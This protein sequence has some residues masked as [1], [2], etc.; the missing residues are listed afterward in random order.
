MLVSAALKQRKPGNQ[1]VQSGSPSR[2]LATVPLLSHISGGFNLAPRVEQ[3]FYSITNNTSFLSKGCFTKDGLGFGGGGG[4]GE[5][6]KNPTK[7][8]HLQACWS[9]PEMSCSSPSKGVSQLL[10]P[11]Q[12]H[13]V[14]SPRLLGWGGGASKWLKW[15]EENFKV[16]QL[17]L[18]FPSWPYTVS[19]VY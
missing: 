3:N 17:S 13:P 1:R 10:R 14:P 9:S 8:C 15:M 4:A 18:S 2:P 7:T 11:Y 5:G 6:G 19:F 16:S 12:G